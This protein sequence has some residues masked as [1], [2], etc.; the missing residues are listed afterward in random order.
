LRNVFSKFPGAFQQVNGLEIYSQFGMLWLAQTT[1]K[2]VFSELNRRQTFP[3]IF[4]T[5]TDGH[6]CVQQSLGTFT[7]IFT[8]VFFRDKCK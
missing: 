2:I 3:V 6:Y 8:T 4:T 7:V 1:C 5:N